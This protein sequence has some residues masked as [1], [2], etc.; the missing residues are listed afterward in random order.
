MGVKRDYDR[1]KYRNPADIYGSLAARDDFE[2]K[3]VKTF[4]RKLATKKSRKALR[5]P[6]GAG[7]EK[8][9]IRLGRQLEY[10]T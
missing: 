6:F 7:G 5:S 8:L 1:Q 4:L 10:R 3:L 9:A 2:A